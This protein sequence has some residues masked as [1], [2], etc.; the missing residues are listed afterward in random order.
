MTAV[1]EDGGNPKRTA[2]AKIFVQFKDREKVAFINSESEVHILENA[3]AD[4]VIFVP[5]L[6]NE[7]HNITFEIN[8]VNVTWHGGAKNVL[9]WLK[10]D[11]NSGVVKLK[12]EIDGDVVSRMHVVI[13]AKN[14]DEKVLDK[15]M[16][17][18]IYKQ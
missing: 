13:L 11:E 1:A 12:E 9:N 7:P 2:E 18:R 17:L 16:V 15:C 14:H 6:L 3:T 10:I 4:T 5:K 8:E